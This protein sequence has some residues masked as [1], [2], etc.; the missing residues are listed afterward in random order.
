MQMLAEIESNET[1]TD[2]RKY[3]KGNAGVSKQQTGY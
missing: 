3:A 2:K 1:V